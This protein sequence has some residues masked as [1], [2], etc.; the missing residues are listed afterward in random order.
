M[1][2]SD[3]HLRVSLSDLGRTEEMIVKSSELGYS[4][5]GLPLPP[6][7]SRLSIDELRKICQKYGVDLAMRLELVPKSSSDLLRSLRRFR[8]DF[9]IVSVLCNSKLVARQ[10]A[11]DRRVDL[12]C[13]PNVSLHKHYF[14]WAEAELASR[15]SAAFEI[16][17]APILG[18]QGFARAAMLSRLRRDVAV[19]KEYKVPVVI[20]SGASDP[21]LLR[22]PEDYASLAFLFGMDSTPALESLS[23]IPISIVVR[24]REKLSLGFVTTG[25]RIVEEEKR[26]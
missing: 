23:Q 25:L 17:M 1:K 7:V 19:A 26:S 5:V 24:N 8:R 22:K 13:F 18:V 15:S 4:Q 6:K 11:K 9:E 16:D 10:A 20:S 14:D 2:C 3:L 21:L 12:L